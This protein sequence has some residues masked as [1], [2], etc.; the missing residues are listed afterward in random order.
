[1]L[2]LRPSDPVPSRLITLAYRP[3]S[4]LKGRYEKL[5]ELIQ[6][7]LEACCGRKTPAQLRPA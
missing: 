3:G 7:H 6:S 2:Y 4:P 5:A 1:M